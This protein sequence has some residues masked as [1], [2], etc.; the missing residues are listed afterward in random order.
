MIHFS[1]NAA[2]APQDFCNRCLSVSQQQPSGVAQPRPCPCRM[3]LT[4]GAACCSWS[5]QESEPLHILLSKFDLLALGAQAT[6]STPTTRSQTILFFAT[7][8]RRSS[9]PGMWTCAGRKSLAKTARSKRAFRL[10]T[11]TISTQSTSRV[12]RICASRC[13]VGCAVISSARLAS[14]H[15]SCPWSSTS[16]GTM[17]KTAHPTCTMASGT[18]AAPPF[19]VRLQSCTLLVPS[20]LDGGGSREIA[21]SFGCLEEQREVAEAL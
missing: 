3:L 2:V 16:L 1:D 14:P 12:K 21:G 17:V 4:G 8:T 7:G 6:S 13:L 15:I 20:G 19:R 10:G 18:C 5:L 11:P 9:A